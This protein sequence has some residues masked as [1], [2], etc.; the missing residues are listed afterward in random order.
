MPSAST[1]GVPSPPGRVIT[2][3]MFRRGRSGSGPSQ[4]PPQP[5]RQTVVSLHSLVQYSP[6]TVNASPT[7]SL[8]G[9]SSKTL[10]HGDRGDLRRCAESDVLG[11]SATTPR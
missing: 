10:D 5:M 9:P 4:R 2:I 3:V 8:E 7:L 11:K 1:I 6:R